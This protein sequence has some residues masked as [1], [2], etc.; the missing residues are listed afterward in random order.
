MKF[1]ANAQ[2][3]RVKRDGKLGSRTRES[4]IKTAEQEYVIEIIK[5]GRSNIYECNK[6]DEKVMK[7]DGRVRSGREQVEHRIP[8][9]IIVATH[10]EYDLTKQASMSLGKWAIEFGLITD[11]EHDLLRSRHSSKMRQK[12]IDKA[13]ENGIIE[14]EQTKLLDEFTQYCLEIYGQLAKTLEHMKKC[15]IIL[16]YENWKGYGK[17]GKIDINPEIMKQIQKTRRRLMKKYDVVEFNLIAH[18][19]AR[20]VKSFKCEWKQALAEVE[21]ENGNILGIKYYWKEYAMI[22]KATSKAVQ[23]YLEMYCADALESYVSE[24]EQFINENEA[25]Y[26]LKRKVNIMKKAEKHHEQRLQEYKEQNIRFATEE[27]EVFIR[28]FYTQQELEDIFAGYDLG[29][30]RLHLQNLYMERMRQLFDL[31]NLKGTNFVGVS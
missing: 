20:K 1:G 24:K 3:A 2:K 30:K 31:Y 4:I 6:R 11:L 29:V 23:R 26:V 21:D 5:Q 14:E 27:E 28:L 12:H 22:L 18:S 9:D 10:L 25:D 15:G 7:K 19:N 16:F 13:I 17:D 8:M